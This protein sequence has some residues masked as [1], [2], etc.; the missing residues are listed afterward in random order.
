M[1]TFITALM[2]SLMFA[3]S[4]LAA[5]VPIAGEVKKINAAAGKIT[6]KHEAITNLDMGA[7][8]MVFA[9]ADPSMLEAVAVGDQVTFEADRIKGKITVVSLAAQQD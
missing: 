1:K 8:T 9:V 7:M 2:L 6:L 5:T 3:G 4:S